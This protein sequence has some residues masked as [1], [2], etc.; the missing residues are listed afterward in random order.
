MKSFA[1]KVNSFNQNLQFRL[2]LP[3]GIDVMNPFQNESVQKISKAFYDKFYSDTKT[4]KLILGINPGRLGAGSTGIPFTDTKRLESECN[5]D[6]AQFHTHEPSSVFIYEV[7]NSYGGPEAFYQDFYINSVCPLGFLR[8]NSKG[9][10]VNCNYYDFPELFEVTKNYIKENIATQIKMG[11]NTEV[12][13][14]LGK[15]NAK[16]FKLINDE[17]NFFNKIVALDHPRYIVQYKSKEMDRYVQ[18]YLNKLEN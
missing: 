8:L 7:I 18:D 3:T 13:Y 11:V 2:P 6:L 5:I 16:F 14:I 1:S 10:W 9:N 12:V 15:K 17:E 4:R